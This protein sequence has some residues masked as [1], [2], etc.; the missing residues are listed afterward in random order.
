MLH[1]I[2]KMMSGLVLT[3]RLASPEGIIDELYGP[4]VVFIPRMPSLGL[5]LEGPIFDSYNTK[6]SAVNQKLQPTDVEYRPPIDFS[7]HSSAIGEFKQKYIY[8]TMRIV[9]DRHGLFDQWI[10]SVDSYGG[11]DLL[12]FNPRGTIPEAAVIKKD[13]RRE[14]AFKERRL[15]N[16]TSFSTDGQSSL[17]A[18]YVIEDSETEL[19]KRALADTEG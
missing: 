17:K 6:V 3:C 11:N 13:Q 5:L 2:R 7:L 19:G 12:Y 10:R 18:E 9:E 4:K 15:F 16:C 8:D 1:Q 14:N